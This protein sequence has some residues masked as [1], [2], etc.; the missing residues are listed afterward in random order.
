MGREATDWARSCEHPTVQKGTTPKEPGNFNSAQ[1]LD[2]HISR[3]SIRNA[4][5]LVKARCPEEHYFLDS[6]CLIGAVLCHF[7]PLLQKYEIFA[8]RHCKDWA[9]SLGFAY[10]CLLIGIGIRG[11]SRNH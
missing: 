3:D 1:G 9:Q 5:L 6:I 7:I 11:C 2:R 8:V 10:L 4:E